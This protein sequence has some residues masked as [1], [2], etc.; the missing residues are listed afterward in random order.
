MSHPQSS[1][2]PFPEPFP[3][4]CHNTPSHHPQI[5]AWPAAPKLPCP[6]EASGKYAPSNTSSQKQQARAEVRGGGAWALGC[7]AHSSGSPGH[8]SAK[9]KTAF[10]LGDSVSIRETCKQE[11]KWK[12]LPHLPLVPRGSPPGTHG[13]PDP[14]LQ[15]FSRPTG[16]HPSLHSPLTASSVTSPTGQPGSRGIRKP[17]AS[18]GSTHPTSL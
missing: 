13:N 18:C 11:Q 17:S 2:D 3:P 14:C 1:P 9:D 16:H 8:L 12:Y 5:H 6:A 7:K 4:A 15:G 10:H